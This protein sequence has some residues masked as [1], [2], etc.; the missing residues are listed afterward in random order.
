MLHL[1]SRPQLAGNEHQRTSLR[2]IAVGAIA[3]FATA[4]QSSLRPRELPLPR[5]DRRT[6]TDPSAPIAVGGSGV[7]AFTDVTDETRRTAIVVDSSGTR[8]GRL[9]PPSP[10]ASASRI[11]V[12]LRN[13]GKQILETPRLSPRQSSVAE[14]QIR[15]SGVRRRSPL[16]PDGV[17]HQL[18]APLA[19]HATESLTQ[20]HFTSRVPSL[21]F[22]VRGQLW[23]V[24]ATTSGSF[25]DI[26]DSTKFVERVKLPCRP[27]ARGIAVRPPWVALACWQRGLRDTAR[28]VIRLFRV[29]QAR[30]K[31]IPRM[32]TLCS[33]Q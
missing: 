21:A 24:G 12:I 26:V 30:W 5:L 16:G 6:V 1:P 2:V 23:V 27:T 14:R 22:D 20:E 3:A 18:P 8:L 13:G 10:T 33:L 32:A 11:V 4:P 9:T 31:L 7:L 28:A 15:D 25:T 19:A 17:R 29:E